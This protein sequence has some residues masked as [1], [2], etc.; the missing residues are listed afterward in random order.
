MHRSRRSTLVLGLAFVLA[1]IAF[2]GV[3]SSAYAYVGTDTVSVQ[4]QD[5]MDWQWMYWFNTL[6]PVATFSSSATSGVIGG[7][8]YD[9]DR[10]P[11]TVPT[12]A[13]EFTPLNSPLLSAEKR[14]DMQGLAY[15][16]PSQHKNGE[17]LDVEGVWYIH[18]RSIIAT[19]P[20]MANTPG[21]GHFGI[22]LTKPE[23]VRYVR[24]VPFEAGKYGVTAYMRTRVYWSDPAYWTHGGDN[25]YDALSG[26]AQWRLTVNGVQDATWRRE[27]HNTTT[28]VHVTVERGLKNGRNVVG[29]QC[30]DYAG[31][32]SPVT[33]V[34]FYVDT[35]V[36]AIS[37]DQPYQRQC[38]YG[39]VPF[40]V[41]T[42]DAGGIREVVFKIDGVVKQAGTSNVMPFD[43]HKL[44]N[45]QH[46]VTVTVRDLYGRATTQE[47]IFSVDNAPISSSS[48][49]DSPDPFYP[50][51][52]E[53]YKDNSRIAYHLGKA[54]ATVWVRIWNGSKIVRQYTASNVAVGDHSATWDGRSSDGTIAEGT[55]YYQIVAKG[56][57][58]ATYST[59][60]YP[61]TIRF[62]ELVRVA[63]NQYKVVPR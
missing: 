22:D 27:E 39:T 50:R 24:N 60:K 49:G 61:T 36:P 10:T 19:A 26:D 55:F 2:L 54:A 33:N 11:W 59:T 38:I 17:R 15:R 40:T 58:G 35:D 5:V 44:E 62:W 1:L 18:A 4:D 41:A 13:S 14:L 51:L 42:H 9:V 12:R 57:N 31:N 32:V 48:V 21:H 28:T 37:I 30:I 56:Y 7:F 47:K 23:A 46:K 25:G 29:V 8:Y 3:C 52:R 53:G 43:T 34:T 63:P 6:T 16:F 45:G 20:G